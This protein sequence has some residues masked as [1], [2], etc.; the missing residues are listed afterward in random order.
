MLKVRIFR[1]WGR[2]RF[3]VAAYWRRRRRPCTTRR[4]PS[5]AGSDYARKIIELYDFSRAWANLR[6]GR[7]RIVPGANPS[8]CLSRPYRNADM[9]AKYGGRARRQE[10]MQN[11]GGDGGGR[12]SPDASQDRASPKLAHPRRGAGRGVHACRQRAGRNG[13]AA[14]YLS[15]AAT[16]TSGTARSIRDL[17]FVFWT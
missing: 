17:L 9:R 10:P 14:C 3:A 15:A 2:G 7:G 11:S 12:R 8:S 13:H 5:T 6:A 4:G 1:L 16:T